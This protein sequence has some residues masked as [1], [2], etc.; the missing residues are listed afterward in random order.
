MAV[1]EALASGTPAIIA[2]VQPADGGQLALAPWLTARPGLADSI[3]FLADPA[4][5]GHRHS[6]LQPR[7][8]SAGR[9]YS[10]AWKPSTWRAP[11][12]EAGSP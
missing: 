1:L 12:G 2:R 6:Y 11:A 9:R 4:L 8:R 5:R 10:I 3:R 7:D